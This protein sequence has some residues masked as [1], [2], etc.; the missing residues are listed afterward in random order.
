MNELES[1]RLIPAKDL[2]DR[3]DIIDIQCSN[4]LEYYRSL[5]AQRSV[6]LEAIGVQALSQ[7]AQTVQLDLLET[8]AA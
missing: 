5:L 6:V 3:L 4:A 8:V 1:Y 7:P 2:M